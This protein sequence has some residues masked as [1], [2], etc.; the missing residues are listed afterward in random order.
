MYPPMMPPGGQGGQGGPG[1]TADSML[2]EDEIKVM[3]GFE[4][5]RSEPEPDI[6]RGGVLEA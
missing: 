3:F 1:G 4:A 6:P 2:H 5:D